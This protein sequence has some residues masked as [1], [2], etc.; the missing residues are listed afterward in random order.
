MDASDK[1]VGM[2]TLNN[3]IDFCY[4]DG[5]DPPQFDIH[6]YLLAGI[7]TGDL[8]FLANFLCHQGASARWLCMFCLA[9][10][11]ELHQA[12]RLTGDPPRSPKRQGPTSMKELYKIYKRK[13]L[14]L[15]PKLNTKAKK[16]QLTRELSFSVVGLSSADVPSDAIAPATMHVILG[17]TKSIRVFVGIV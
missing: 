3:P 14:D 13:Y 10:Q 4:K 15:D 5:G 12:F 6:R 17:L 8:D 2:L 1:I 11:S 7:F 16:E 9:R